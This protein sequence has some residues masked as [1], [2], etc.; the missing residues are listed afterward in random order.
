MRLPL[1]H[2][3]GFPS[4]GQLSKQLRLVLAIRLVILTEDFVKPDGWLNIDIGTLP[5]IPRQVGLR[6]ADDQAPIDRSYI[7]FSC[8]RQRV[9]KGRTGSTGHIF[10]AQ[11]G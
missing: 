8:D 6:L 4:S 2:I 9:I 11:D 7:V 3:S 1:L 5:G 10:G